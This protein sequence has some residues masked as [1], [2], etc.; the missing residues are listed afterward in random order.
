M[1]QPEPA[2]EFANIPDETKVYLEVFW[3]KGRKKRKGK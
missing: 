3:V 1:R 2:K